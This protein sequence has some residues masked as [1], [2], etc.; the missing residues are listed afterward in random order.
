MEKFYYVTLG[1][2]QKTPNVLF[3]TRWHSSSGCYVSKLTWKQNTSGYDYMKI[4][5]KQGPVCF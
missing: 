1:V 2:E 5:I 4:I 3:S